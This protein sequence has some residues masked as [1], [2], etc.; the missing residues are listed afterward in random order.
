[1]RV[2]ARGVYR[3][4]H[5]IR[6]GISCIHGH[7]NSIVVHKGRLYFEWAEVDLYQGASIRGGN[8]R[9]AYELRPAWYVVRLRICVIKR[10]VIP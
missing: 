1:M 8:K 7:R 3:D 10:K 5:I 9:V 2:R 4:C 6:E